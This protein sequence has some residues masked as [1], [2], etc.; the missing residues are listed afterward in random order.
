MLHCPA[1]FQNTFIVQPNSRT[2]ILVPAKVQDITLGPEKF[3]S[4]PK[5]VEDG[6]LIIPGLDWESTELIKEKKTYLMDL[7]KNISLD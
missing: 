1:N 2:I 4:Y 5:S 6:L 3:F 7:T